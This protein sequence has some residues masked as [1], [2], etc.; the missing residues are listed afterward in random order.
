MVEVYLHSPI[1]IHDTV[2]NELRRG[3]IFFLHLKFSL[4]GYT[5]IRHILNLHCLFI[6]YHVILYILYNTTG[7]L[8]DR[9]GPQFKKHSSRPTFLSKT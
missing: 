2:L 1:H 7:Y 5:M 6:T 8:V 3:T 9:Q 4:K